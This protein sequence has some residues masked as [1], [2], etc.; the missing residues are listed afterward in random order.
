MAG[1]SNAPRWRLR[2]LVAAGA[3]A[4][5]LG[6]GYAALVIAFPPERVAALVSDQVTAR[7]GRD[8]R[9]DGKLS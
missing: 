5:L 4:V 6:G 8:F 2:L 3:I 1:T 7:T 9:I